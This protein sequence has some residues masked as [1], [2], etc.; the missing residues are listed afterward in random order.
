MKPR[1]SQR[2]RRPYVSRSPNWPCVAFVHE[3]PPR[4]GLALVAPCLHAGRP[5]APSP[6][7]E[8]A[9]GSRSAEPAARR[10]C[11]SVGPATATRQAEIKSPAFEHCPSG[12]DAPS[13]RLTAGGA[14]RA[15]GPSRAPSSSACVGPHVSLHAGG[16]LV[17]A[18]LRLWCPCRSG[19]M[20]S[21][22]QS[23]AWAASVISHRCMVGRLAVHCPR[24][25]EAGQAAPLCVCRPQ[26][27]VTSGAQRQTRPPLQLG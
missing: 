13:L 24:K 18:S 15:V 1:P 2:R 12:A 8:A 17:L 25:A 14:G 23:P 9:T 4:D 11:G 10:R 7:I 21:A 27:A 6:P 20:R 16:S 3:P 22:V 26:R 19:S 5:C